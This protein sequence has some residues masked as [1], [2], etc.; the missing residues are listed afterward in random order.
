MKTICLIPGDGVGKEVIPATADVLRTLCEDLVFTHAEAGFDCFRECGTSLPDETLNSARQADAVLFG[1]TSSP[2]TLVFGYS[3]PILKLRKEFDL[4]ANLRPTFSLPGKYSQQGIDLLI[5]RENSEG[6]YSGREHRE[7]DTAIA[8]RVI[9]THASQ[10]IVR[11]ACEQAVKRWKL[12]GKKPNLTIV[13]KANVLKIT[14]GLFRECALEVVQ[15]FPELSV[16]ELLVDAA[17]MNLLKNPQI[18]DVMVTTNLFGDILSDEASGLVGGLG[19]AASANVGCGIPVFEPV[20]GSA[21]D[22]AGQGIANPVGSL[23]SGVMMLEMLDMKDA[24]E[25]LKKAVID[26]LASGVL[27]PDLGGNATTLQFTHAVSYRLD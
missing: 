17:A 4:Y 22:I 27:T 19:V 8:E 20:H 18:F 24:A 11:M 13:H 3:S 26:V 6:L 5:V 7:D 12:G 2:S 16:R 25:R 21:P 9:T 15:E 14:D 1:A 23:F 10:R